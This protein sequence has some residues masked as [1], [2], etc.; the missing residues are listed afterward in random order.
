M[1]ETKATPGPWEQGLIPKSAS[2]MHQITSPYVSIMIAGPPLGVILALWIL[3]LV[4]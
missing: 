1:S 4:G 2:K 3:K